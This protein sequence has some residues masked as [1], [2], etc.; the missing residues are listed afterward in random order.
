MDDQRSVI[1]H[2]ISQLKLGMDLTRVWTLYLFFICSLLCSLLILLCV[3]VHSWFLW[4]CFAP[5]DSGG[6]LSIKVWSQR[7]MEGCLLLGSLSYEVTTSDILEIEGEGKKKEEEENILQNCCFF[8]CESFR[9]TRCC[10][11]NPQVCQSALV[12]IMAIVWMKDIHVHITALWIGFHL[13]ASQLQKKP[14][15]GKEI[16]VFSISVLVCVE[17]LTTFTFC[18]FFWS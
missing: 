2:L 14:H 16:A 4:V 9:V 17:Q 13:I 11:C 5:V 15:D 3:C 18:A 12:T 7:A 8:S 6:F 10:V 1:L